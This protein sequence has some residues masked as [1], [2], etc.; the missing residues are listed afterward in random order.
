MTAALEGQFAARWRAAGGPKRLLL[1]VSGGGDSIALLRLC[2]PL[3]EAGVTLHVATVDHGLRPQSAADAEFVSE[4]SRRFGLP[5]A[6]LRWGGAKPRTGVQAAA[7]ARRYR[8]LAGEAMRIGADAI[9]TA[10]TADDQAETILMRIAHRTGVRGLAG[11]APE[12]LIADGAGPPQRLLRLL[13]EERRAS[14]R[15]YLSLSG[16]RFIDDPSNDDPVFERVRARRLL[17]ASSDTLAPALMT[18]AGRARALQSLADRLERRQ[19]HRAEGN[20]L[21]DGGVLL[22]S[23][24]DP[25]LAARLLRAVGGGDHDPDDAAAADALAAARN[26]R[27]STLA[28]AIVEPCDGGL[29]IRREPAAVLGRAGSQSLS[30][31]RLRPGE[32]LLWDRRF[33]VTNIFSAPAEVRPLGPDAKALQARRLPGLETAPGLFL[34]GRLAAFAGDDGAGEVAIAN[35]VPERFARAVLRF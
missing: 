8:L 3:S 15:E 7:R 20:F 24:D 16:A 10:H 31:L 22:S 32:R 21:A 12:N 34:D 28:G 35:L 1:A 23:L 18:L 25:G 11:M 14:L 27:R 6:I 19:F 2:L 5:C 9:L 17:R 33:S 30:A 13:I 4:E 29:L 26:G